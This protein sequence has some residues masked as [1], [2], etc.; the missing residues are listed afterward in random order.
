MLKLLTCLSLCFGWGRIGTKIPL[1]STSELSRNGHTASIPQIKFGIHTTSSTQVGKSILTG[2]NVLLFQRCFNPNPAHAIGQLFELQGVNCVLQDVSFNVQNTFEES[3]LVRLLF[4]GTSKTLRNVVQNG[5]NTTTIGFGPDMLKSPASFHPGVS[6]FFEYGGHATITLK[7]AA[8]S[9]PTG[10]PTDSNNEIRDILNPGNGLQYIKLGTEQLR[11]SKGVEA[12]A[13]VSYA[14]GWVD[15]DTPSGIPMEVVVG[16]AKD[17]LMMACLRCTSVP[18]SV[19]F[20]KSQLGMI[21][22]PY[23]YARQVGSNFEPQ[24]RPGAVYLSYG[25]DLFGILLSPTLNAKKD[26]KD[27]KNYPNFNAYKNTGSIDVGN[28]LDYFKIVIDDKA[29]DLPPAAV[30]LVESGEDEII[31]TSPDGYR[32]KLQRYSAFEKSIK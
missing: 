11:I 24:L 6:S 27:S 20:F 10:S 31:V 23:P 32:F 16:V 22:V 13:K 26:A 30:K 1:M 4:Q 12:G 8:P 25:A 29:R 15:L 19:E 18:E 9:R 28:V 5:A 2:L 7:S 17:P 21:E 3:E 14:Y